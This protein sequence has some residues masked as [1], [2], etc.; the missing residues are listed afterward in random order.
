MTENIIKTVDLPAEVAPGP[1][2]LLQLADIFQRAGYTKLAAYLRG[3]GDV[4]AGKN[5]AGISDTQRLDDL[6]KLVDDCGG[7]LLLHHGHSITHGIPGLGLRHIGRTL[8][9]AIDNETSP[10]VKS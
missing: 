3:C 9:Q 5:T 10:K 7:L 8:R 4:V 2:G 6:E 1:M